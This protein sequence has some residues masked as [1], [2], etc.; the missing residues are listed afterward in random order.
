MKK[1]KLRVLIIVIAIFSIIFNGIYV[2]SSKK[3]IYASENIE[4]IK[5]EIT[6]KGVTVTWNKVSGADKYD[7]SLSAKQNNKEIL[8]GFIDTSTKNKFTYSW[9]RIKSDGCYYDGNSYYILFKIFAFDKDFNLITKQESRYIKIYSSKKSE[10]S[11]KHKWKKI[12]KKATIKKDGK[13]TIQCKKCNR[14]CKDIIIESAKKITLS[15]Y[16]FTYDGTPKKPKVTVKDENGKKIKSKNYT[17]KYDSKT[18]KVGKHTVTIKF[19]NQYKGIVK[20]NY[21]VK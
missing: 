21:Y 20:V 12:T 18:K 16:T 3:N 9:Q 5:L 1:I 2:D 6:K 10:D 7:I 4:N 11:C 15:R 13:I 17:V 19:K 14:Y 8:G